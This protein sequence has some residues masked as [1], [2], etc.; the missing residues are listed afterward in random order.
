MVHKYTE[1][2]S[3]FIAENVKGIGNKK[4]TEIFN[5]YFGLELGINQIRAYVKNNKFQSGLNGQ[6]KKGHIP[7]NKG[8]HIGGWEPT[9]FKKGSIP[10]NHRPLGSE[11]ITVDGYTEVKVT[12]PRTWKLKQ[13]IVWEE[14]NGKIPKGYLV[15][16]GDG[17][18]QNFE[19]DNL[20]LVSRKQLVTMNKKKL[21]KNDAELT[22]TGVIIA[23][24]YLK[25]SDRK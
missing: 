8:K 12:E 20:I 16:F 19:L 18:K 22:R 23:D 11:R 9:Q 25:I 14:H 4:L 2:Q 21:I 13:R 5:N 15:L 17:N 3:E 6:F 24:L 10:H 1:V 7:F